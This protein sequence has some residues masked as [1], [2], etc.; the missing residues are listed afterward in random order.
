M[1]FSCNNKPEILIADNKTDSATSAIEISLSDLAKIYAS[2]NGQFIV[3]KGQFSFLF[4]QVGIHDD[5]LFASE[6]DCFWLRFKNVMYEQEDKLSLL[7]GKRVTIKGKVNVNS[8][9]HLGSYLASID[10]VYFIKEE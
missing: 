2:L 8:K 3:T 6:T 7:S 10:S 1:L 5:A 9:G 4:E